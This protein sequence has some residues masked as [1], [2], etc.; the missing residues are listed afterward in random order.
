MTGMACE[1]GVGH[2]VGLVGSQ[3]PGCV[4]AELCMSGLLYV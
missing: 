4:D 2:Q 3:W 1:Q